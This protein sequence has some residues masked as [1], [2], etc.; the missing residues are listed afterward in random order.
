MFICMYIF[1]IHNSVLVNNKI[2]KGLIYGN[3]SGHFCMYTCIMDMQTHVYQVSFQNHA[4]VKS[5]FM[6]CV[7]GA[8][9]A[10][11]DKMCAHDEFAHVVHI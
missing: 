10:F 4:L 5:L 7:F 9:H 1:F 3:V 2:S 11:D 8:P 6:W